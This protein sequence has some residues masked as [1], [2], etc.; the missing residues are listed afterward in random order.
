[1][2]RKHFIYLAD[3]IRADREHFD[4]VALDA[5]SGFCA[6]FNPQFNRDR[7]LDYINGQCTAHGGKIK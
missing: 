2:T 1:M 6:T 7:W 3:C 4:N 5:L